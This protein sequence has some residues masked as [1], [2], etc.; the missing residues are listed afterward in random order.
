ML[1]L[2]VV[3]YMIVCD[4]YEIDPVRAHSLNVY[5]VISTI[6]SQEDPP[7]PLVHRELCVLLMLSE[8]RGSG[9]GYIRCVSEESGEE[10][11]RTATYRIQFGSDPLELFG[12]PFRLH[13]C[14]FPAAGLYAIEFWYNDRKLDERVVRLR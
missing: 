1:P 9:E 2:P 14:K 7:Y 4:D 11:H 12:V 6:R 13:G 10:I 3:R 8:C 5:G